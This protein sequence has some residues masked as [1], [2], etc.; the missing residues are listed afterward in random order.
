MGALAQRIC[1]TIGFISQQIK[2]S[3]SAESRSAT[4]VFFEN[5]ENN[6]KIYKGLLGTRAQMPSSSPDPFSC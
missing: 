1:L 5:K 2:A 4:M 3:G 6:K